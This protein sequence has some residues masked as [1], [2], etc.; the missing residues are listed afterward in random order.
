MSTPYFSCVRPLAVFSIR[1]NALLTTEDGAETPI[2]LERGGEP[3]RHLHPN[4]NRGYDLNLVHGNRPQVRNL[5]QFHD[6][7]HAHFD[8]VV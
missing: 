5:N 7:R 3:L 2:Q 8:L 6:L 1:G 4:L